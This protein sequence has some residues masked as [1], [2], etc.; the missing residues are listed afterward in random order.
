M[1][2]TIERLN[3]KLEAKNVDRE[4]I[5][6]K[7]RTA[8]GLEFMAS[9]SIKAMISK[10]EASTEYGLDRFGEVE[11]WIS[12]DLSEF[13][14]CTQFFEQYMRNEHYIIVDFNNGILSYPQGP[15]LIIQ[16]DGSVYDQD[17]NK[18]I[19]KRSDYKD[20]DGEIDESKRNQ[21]IEA[22]ME[23]SGYFSGVFRVDYYG[24]VFPVNT[25]EKKG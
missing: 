23:K 17:S 20:E 22:Y 21:L 25:T 15:N 12:L 9:K 5:I 14:D 2:K 16:D 11:S 7:L 10:L 4:A 13:E 6:A 19:I 1:N 18:L 24:N 3:Q 8:W